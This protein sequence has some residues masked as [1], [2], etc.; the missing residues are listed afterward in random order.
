MLWPRFAELSKALFYKEW[1][2]ASK[3]NNVAPL[4]SLHSFFYP[5]KSLVFLILSLGII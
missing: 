4:N 5:N 3:S 1:W 2:A